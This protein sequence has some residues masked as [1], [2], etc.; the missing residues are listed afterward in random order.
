MVRPHKCFEVYRADEVAECWDGVPDALYKTLWG[1]IVPNQ[2]D[3]PNLEDNGPGDV[4]GW[5]CLASHWARL[6]EDEQR[7]LNK[8]AESQP[9]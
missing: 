3:I 5:E 9:R 7:E 8:L 6:T 4:V 1:V 2:K